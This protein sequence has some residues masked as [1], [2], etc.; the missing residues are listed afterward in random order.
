MSS[1]FPEG[2]EAGSCRLIV[3]IY[4][5]FRSWFASGSLGLA[6]LAALFVFHR[7]VDFTPRVCFFEH[8]SFVMQ[9]SAFAKCDHALG[10]RAVREVHPQRDQRQPSFFCSAGESIELA[11]VQK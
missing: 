10:D 7:P 5:V 2:T 1:S 6:P 4:T 9:F 11:S 8:F 3:S